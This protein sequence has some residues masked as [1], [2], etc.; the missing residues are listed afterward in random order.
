MSDQRCPICRG[1]LADGAHACST[2][3]PEHA[4]TYEVASVEDLGTVIRATLRA[5]PFVVERVRRRG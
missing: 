3:P 5:V 1:A 4:P 2:V